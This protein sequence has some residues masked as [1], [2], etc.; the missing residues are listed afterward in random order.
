MAATPE[1][2]TDLTGLAALRGAA[3]TD[4][5]SAETLRKVANQFEALFTQMLLKSMR[6]ASFG[7]DLFESDENNLY[8]DL[9][10]RQISLLL[11]KQKGLGIADMLVRQLGSNVNEQRPADA[12]ASGAAPLQL[13][14]RPEASSAA[15]SAP[16]P[17]AATVGVAFKTP[18]DFVAALAPHAEAAA[19]DLG[20]RPEALLAIA[21]LE[22]GWGRAIMRSADGVPSHNLFGIKA[23]RRWDGATVSAQTIE[24]EDGVAVRRRE[25][26]RAYDSYAESFADFARFVRANP[27]YQK[28]L[29]KAADPKAFAAALQQAGYATDPSYGHKVST[30]LDGRAL[31]F[32]L[33][34]DGDRPLTG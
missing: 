17:L 23:D 22:T 28:A 12:P 18:A 15:A 5:K 21:A 31:Q 9:Y 6:D 27:R 4:P 29:A 3:K 8:R 13:P 30:I 10:D 16:A 19:R 33:K 1:I 11:A 34:S 32:A 14:T 20:T 7:N 25:P 24:Y 2:S 26:F